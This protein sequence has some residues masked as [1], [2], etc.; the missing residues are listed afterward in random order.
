MAT[1]PQAAA[2]AA[3]LPYLRRHARALC[4]SQPR[5]DALVA[6]VLR[7]LAAS[8]GDLDLAGIRLVLFKRLHDAWEAEGPAPSQAVNEAERERSAQHHLRQI[9]PE[10]RQALLLSVTEGFPLEDIS[11]IL[12]RTPVEVAGLI[13]EAHEELDAMEQTDIL[14]IEDEPI[15]ALDLERI[16]GELGHNVTGVADTAE[17]AVTLAHAQRPGLVLA[18]I[19][20]ADGSSGID[21]V[22]DILGAFEVPVIFITAYPER[23]LSGERP[24]PAFLITKPF[25]TDAVKIAIGRALFFHRPHLA[26][27]S[28][29]ALLAK[30]PDA[31]R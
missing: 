27:S 11:L 16:A 30:G 29:S 22:N 9:V 6:D 28:Q 18:D 21:A 5:G 19:R 10:A 20:L 25:T 17:A 15:I 7:D 1:S 2:I 13:D 4:G 31:Q 3:E 12:E 8:P 23:L 14:I 26:E 24:E